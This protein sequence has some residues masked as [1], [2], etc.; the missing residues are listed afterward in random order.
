MYFLRSGDCCVYAVEAKIDKLGSPKLC[1]KLYITLSSLASRIATVDKDEKKAIEEF[2]GQIQYFERI[3]SDLQ[4][5]IDE[6]ADAPGN[7]SQDYSQLE[8][9][10]RTCTSKL[11]E[12]VDKFK[13]SL[14]KWKGPLHRF[15]WPLKDVERRGL[16]DLVNQYKN[17]I[18][19]ELTVKQSRAIQAVAAAVQ[20][21]WYNKDILKWLKVEGVEVNSNFDRAR[22]KC[23]P[24]TGQWF[25][26][27]GAFD[28]FRGGVGECIWLHGIPGAG[29][30]ILSGS[31]IAAMRTHVESK[32]STGLA[33]F[34]SYTDKDKQNTFNMLSS[35]ALQLAER[36]TNIPSRVITLYNNNK[37][38]P[39]RSV[40]LEVITRLARCFHQTYILLDDLDEIAAEER[41][42]LLKA[43]SEI[44]AKAR[45]SNIN[46]LMTCRREP[47]LV[48]GF[49]KL[50]LE[51]ISLTTSEVDKDIKLY[52]TEIV[53][54]EP[55]LSR[56]SVELRA[57]IVQ[58]LSDKAMGM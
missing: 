17:S 18:Q 49:Q 8:T 23:H 33:Y 53:D 47:Y 48:D 56:W 10:L 6:A 29:K 5:L 44:V 28:R 41:S 4:S 32:P 40:V 50:L 38:R 30:T 54:K 16:V 37:P 55:K 31:I 13:P 7:M 34:F 21:E 58:T 11:Q 15:T 39:P 51:E 46:L 1:K 52:V 43:L 20:A 12:F 9:Y 14:S 24:G 36:I 19:L 26:Q 57:E 3:L 25:L 45:L 35:I 27:S 42:S 22:E 2:K